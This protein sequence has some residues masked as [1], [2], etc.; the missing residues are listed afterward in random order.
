MN[1]K[2]IQAAPTI[3]TG[4]GPLFTFLKIAILFAGVN[5]T[6][7]AK[8]VASVSNLMSGMQV[9][10]L[11]SVLAVGSSILFLIVERISYNTK[12]KLPLNNIQDE[13]YLLFDSISSEKFLIELLKEAKIQNK[14]TV[15]LVSAIPKEFAKS[16]DESLKKTLVPYL[17]NLAYGVNKLQNKMTPK[18]GGNG[19]IVDDLFK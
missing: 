12:C 15:D 2:F 14:N 13:F 1:Y 4:L 5:F 6:T 3:L 10:A 8:T 11:C 17:E 18:V 7:Q 9:A 19:D 16:F